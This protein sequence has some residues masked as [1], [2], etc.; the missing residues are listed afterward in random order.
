[1]GLDFQPRPLVLES[2]LGTWRVPAHVGAQFRSWRT[3]PPHLH[4]G[5]QEP[6]SV[7]SRQREGRDACPAFRFLP[8]P[9]A[10]RGT[11]LSV[12]LGQAGILSGLSQTESS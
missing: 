11:T 3:P 5:A 8:A 10:A 6:G 4:P 12:M 1:M 2:S 7:E 9:A